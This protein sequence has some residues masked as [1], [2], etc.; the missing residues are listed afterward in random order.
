MEYIQVLVL[1]QTSV[2]F[3]QIC[4]MKLRRD[5]VAVLRCGFLD[6]E[7]G[8]SLFLLFRNSKEIPLSPLAPSTLAW[9]MSHLCDGQ[10]KWCEL[11]RISH[12][13]C[14]QKMG[15]PFK[16]WNFKFPIRSRVLGFESEYS[17]SDCTEFDS[18]KNFFRGGPVQ[19]VT[20]IV[21]L[22]LKLTSFWI[23]P[24]Q[25]ISQILHFLSAWLAGWNN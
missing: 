8:G 12:P 18:A 22:Q 19:G 3:W 4:G 20:V 13:S 23:I 2:W 14:I 1:E 10:K 16:I 25:I 6:W 9:A 7:E 5:G 17:D 11:G 24:S 21:G 15:F